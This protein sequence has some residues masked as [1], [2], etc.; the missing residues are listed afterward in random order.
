MQWGKCSSEYELLLWYLLLLAK[1]QTKKQSITKHYPDLWIPWQFSSP[2]IFWKSRGVSGQ[3]G[4][5]DVPVLWR[6]LLSAFECCP[7]TPNAHSSVW[8][9]IPECWS[10]F[11]MKIIALKGK[12]AI[13]CFLAN[14]VS[15]PPTLSPFSS[16]TSLD[17][18]F[19]FP[20]V[21]H[22]NWSHHSR[23]TAMETKHFLSFQSPFCH[24]S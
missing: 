22:W 9:Q 8:E 15:S 13:S 14:G 1:N 23:F 7:H 18:I 20:H 2:E 16:H 19:L 3:E 24:G 6:T 11:L 10:E 12:C 4:T 5:T 21:L 17:H